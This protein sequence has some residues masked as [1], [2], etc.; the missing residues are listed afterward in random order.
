MATIQSVGSSGCVQGDR[1]AIDEDLLLALFTVVPLLGE[2][3]SEE[4]RAAEGALA[5]HELAAGDIQ[6]HAITTPRWLALS[7]HH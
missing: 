6:H 7:L 4:G 3:S 1:I 2:Q 5:R